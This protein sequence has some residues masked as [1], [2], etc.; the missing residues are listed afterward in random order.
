MFHHR[1]TSDEVITADGPEIYIDDSMRYKQC[2]S[3]GVVSRSLML[4]MKRMGL[5]VTRQR[6]GAVQWFDIPEADEIEKTIPYCTEK[7]TYVIRVGTPPSSCF[8][9]AF[10]DDTIDIG[11]TGL[12]K[13]WNA[14]PSEWA[15][16]LK[17]VKRAIC[18]QNEYDAW[19]LRQHE[20]RRVEVVHHGLDHNVFHDRKK[21]PH[22]A[23]T[24][25]Y[26]G[27]LH[28]GGE[29]LLKAFNEFSRPYTAEQ[30][31]MI[32]AGYVS[33]AEERDIVQ[34]Y[35]NTNQRVQIY[36]R[37]LSLIDVAN[38]YRA[39]DV[40]VTCSENETWCL[41]IVEAA[42]CGLPSITLINMGR[43]E[44]LTPGVDCF[45]VEHLCWESIVEQMDY[46]FKHRDEAKRRG[47]A[48][49]KMA[50]RFSWDKAAREYLNVLGVK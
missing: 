47:E 4:A 23:W 33:G 50:A 36:Y 43:R 20:F 42:A 18:V 1:T 21:Y 6:H 25:C 40:F 24:F 29:T 22:R 32:V 12:G 39:A 9:Y 49:K 46:T 28:K 14:I 15:T 7:P 35:P 17:N 5:N 44:Y 38:L 10:T 13:A 27:S 16:N 45:A 30:T 37:P 48:A 2:L 19:M 41:P 11:I 31:R 34:R 3:Y 8:K 26:V